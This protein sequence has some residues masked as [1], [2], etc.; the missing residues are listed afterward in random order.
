ME[1]ADLLGKAPCIPV[2]CPP[3]HMD[4]QCMSYIGQVI[5][6]FS[7]SCLFWGTLA[8]PSLPRICNQ[9]PP[10]WKPIFQVWPCSWCL[11][12][13]GRK[14][15]RSQDHDNWS[16]I[17]FCH[18]YIFQCWPWLLPNLLFLVGYPCQEHIFKVSKLFLSRCWFTTNPVYAHGQ[19]IWNCFCGVPTTSENI[20]VLFVSV[21]YKSI[22]PNYTFISC[23]ERITEKTGVHTIIFECNCIL[24]KKTDFW[25]L[26][27]CRATILPW[28]CSSVPS[29]VGVDISSR[30][31]YFFLNYDCLMEADGW[32]WIMMWKVISIFWSCMTK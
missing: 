24:E 29:V 1:L 22:Y 11:L 10:V 21:L 19:T 13:P 32:F 2:D 28:L 16:C 23:E 6:Y 30:D 15:A 9:T 25:F 4:K 20:V 18:W 17:Q 14:G 12:G 8:L 31:K 26:N 7:I 5:K 3:S 27:Y